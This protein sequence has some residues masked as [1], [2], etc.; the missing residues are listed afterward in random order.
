MFWFDSTTDTLP[1]DVSGYSTTVAE[2]IRTSYTQAF[3]HGVI[4]ADTL[5]Y[6]RL[7]GEKVDLSLIRGWIGQCALSHGSQCDLPRSQL[8][9]QPSMKLLLV[10]VQRLALVEATWESRYMALSYVWGHTEGLRCTKANIIHLQ[11][12]G[13]LQELRDELPRTIR[14]AIYL[15]DAVGVKYL[16]VD[17][18][19]IIQDD[20][21]SKGVYISRMGQIYSNA[22]VTLVALTSNNAASALPGVTQPRNLIQT[23]VEINGLAL[24]QR[25]RQLFNVAQDSA[26]SRR[27]WTFQEFIFSRRCLFIS[28]HQAFWQCRSTYQ[29]EDYLDE[30]KRVAP[31]RDGDA[32]VSMIERETGNDPSAQFITYR[33]L[34]MQYSPRHLTFPHDALNAF[35]GILSTLAKRFD[36]KFACALPESHLDLALLWRPQFQCPEPRWSSSE[37]RETNLT[38]PSWCWTAWH[39]SVWWD[40]WRLSA[41]AGQ[42]ASVK[43]EL[44]SVWIRDPSGTRQIRKSQASDHDIQMR[45]PRHWEQTLPPYSLFLKAMTINIEAYTFSNPCLEQSVLWNDGEVGGGLSE[46]YRRTVSASLWIYDAAGRHCGALHDFVNDRK[47]ELRNK[48]H[49]HDL[50]KLSR[51][52]QGQVTAASVKDFGDHL[53]PEYPSD[54]EYYEEVFDTRHYS[55]KSDWAINIML[56]RW[57]DGLAE[58]VAVGQI[59]SDAWNEELQK[60]TMITLI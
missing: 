13:S 10:D 56:V 9:E 48:T 41:Y 20:D 16:W 55:Y 14:D 59:H 8:S 58:R 22:C 60:S 27:A 47:T 35:S 17:A 12:D 3:A 52:I 49:R 38:L 32:M 43:S 42:E 39:C 2:I 30:H 36:W 31:T 50:V 26:W 5:K 53:P 11:K 1:S 54:R 19:C 57:E 34:T 46:Y 21:D 29:S 40:P 51:S 24:V 45:S 23:S 44:G 6:A 25:L 4:Q 7:L 37:R 33:S 15:A 28:E 18:L